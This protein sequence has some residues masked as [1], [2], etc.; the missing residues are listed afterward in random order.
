MSQRFFYGLFPGLTSERHTD[1]FFLKPF[2]GYTQRPK[3]GGIRRRR[4]RRITN[5]HNKQPGP[6]NTEAFGKWPFLENTTAAKRPAAGTLAHN[7]IG[8]GVNAVQKRYIAPDKLAPSSHDIREL[9]ASRANAIS[10]AIGRCGHV[11]Q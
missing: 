6:A 3:V 5:H 1:T 10:S 9:L 8:V 11:S 7:S 2:L 4:R